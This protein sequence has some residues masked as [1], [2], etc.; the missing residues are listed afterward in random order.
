MQKNAVVTGAARGIGEVTAELLASEGAHVVCLDR[1]ADD[2]PCSKVAQRI[3]VGGEEFRVC[4]VAVQQLHQQL[5]EVQPAEHTLTR[6]NQRGTRRFNC[7]EGLQLGAARE[8]HQ[9]RHEGLQQARPATLFGLPARPSGDGTQPAVLSGKYFDDD[10][11]VAIGSTVQHVGRLK[12]YLR[13]NRIAR[14][15]WRDL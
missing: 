15:P 9:Q 10:T 13:I 11:G 7:A 8:R 5:V 4:V 12:F 6:E 1:P 14:R 3:A 2:A